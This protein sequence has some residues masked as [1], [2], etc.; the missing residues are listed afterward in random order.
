[1]S[2]PSIFNH[3]D[4]RFGGGTQPENSLSGRHFRVMAASPFHEE[5]SEISTESEFLVE[6]DYYAG[7]TDFDF[8]ERPG[9]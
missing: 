7:R 4:F 5:S 1:M 6:D 3:P 9:S 8:D 2:H